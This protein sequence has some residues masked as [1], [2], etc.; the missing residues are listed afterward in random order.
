MQFNTQLVVLVLNQVRVNTT[1]VLLT[2][3]LFFTKLSYKRVKT[4]LV[5]LALNTSGVLLT[6]LKRSKIKISL[7]WL[8]AHL[9]KCQT[10]KLL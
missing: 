10:A 3:P 2:Q 9:S 6:I 8:I 7:S 5:K 1:V 4:S